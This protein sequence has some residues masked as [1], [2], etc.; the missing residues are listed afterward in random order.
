M[1]EIK[2][3]LHTNVRYWHNITVPGYQT[4]QHNAIEVYSNTTKISLVRAGQA[5]TWLCTLESTSLIAV[6][7]TLYLHSVHIKHYKSLLLY[8]HGCFLMIIGVNNL[9]I[10]YLIFQLS[11]IVDTG[12][13]SL[14]VASYPR[15]D[16][17]KYFYSKNSTTIYDTGTIVS[18]HVT[19]PKSFN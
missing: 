13:T 14:A 17:D 1:C 8:D 4:F 7:C 19:P 15:Q 2:A 11:L 3:L 9:F 5:A 10:I 6:V 16:N 12:S 18:K